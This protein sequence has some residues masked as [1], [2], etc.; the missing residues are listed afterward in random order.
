M[1]TR[2]D[3]TTQWTVQFAPGQYVMSTQVT[4]ANLKNVI[5]HS[6]P[7]QPAQFSKASTWYN[8]AKAPEFLFYF[9]MAEDVV[10]EG[11]EF[12][13]A[14]DFS[15]SLALVN[16][17][18]G[19]Y[20][21]SGHGVIVQDSKFY[22][23]GNC[24]LRIV[25]DQGDPVPGVNSF[26]TTV[27]GN[28]FHNIYQTATT[29]TDSLHGGTAQTLWTENTYEKLRGSVKFASRTT[30]AKGVKFINNVINGGDHYGLEIDNYTDFVISG[31]TIENILLN[32]IDIYTN[33]SAALMKNGFAW[34]D[35]FTISKNTIKN[36]G[37]PI[38]F[39]HNPFWDGTQSIPKNLVIDGNT[40]SGV[41]ASNS[42]T[43]TI[44]IYGGVFDGVRITH[45]KFSAIS[46]TKYF[47]SLPTGSSNVLIAG[48]TLD[49]VAYGLPMPPEDTAPFTA[50]E[51]SIPSV[52]GD[53][54]DPDGDGIPNLLECALAR[55]PKTSDASELLVLGN[56]QIGSSTY[57]TATFTCRSKIYTPSV[58]T[59]LQVSS[60]M[61]DWEVQP[62]P[63]FV[64]KVDHNDGTLTF[65]Y[66]DTIPISST[67][68]RF[69][70]IKATR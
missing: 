18:Q 36:V 43:P 63:I 60:D 6:D 11:F 65:T 38:R 61:L 27:R 4:V 1:S 34:G 26:N 48:N 12:Y 9:R 55:N 22:N 30:G 42:G 25:T 19:V 10:L 31:N 47:S 67:G 62:L 37:D 66:R 45:N 69:F 29:A 70:K 24:A 52:S 35:N 5:L 64:N 8:D 50:Q 3:K 51:L 28:L 21:G 49:G 54:S 16:N 46:N 13:G 39:D 59:I 2:S 14:T 32:A 33:G 23:F 40:I 56:V 53:D 41:T 44:N 15:K 7:A 58:N 20:F 17:D 68:P 57:L